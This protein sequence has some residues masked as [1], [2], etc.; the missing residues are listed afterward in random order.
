[1]ESL[2]GVVKLMRGVEG[3]VGV[4]LVEVVTC[5]FVADVNRSVAENSFPWISGDDTAGVSWREIGSTVTWVSGG[6][7]TNCCIA[8]DVVVE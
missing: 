2:G 3:G 1:M 5:L 7:G 6:D 8:D 4:L